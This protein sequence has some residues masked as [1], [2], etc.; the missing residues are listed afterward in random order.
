M[1]FCKKALNQIILCLEC[2]PC[3]LLCVALPSNER[4]LGIRAF[5]FIFFLNVSLFKKKSSSPKET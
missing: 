3:Q 4:G 5:S 1:I 2:I